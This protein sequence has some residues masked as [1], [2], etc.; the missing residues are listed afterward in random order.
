MAGSKNGIKMICENRK[1]RHEYQFLEL[2]EA[3][4]S[5]QGTE[6]KSLRLGR[7]NLQDA[8]A[9]VENGEMLL[10]NM[11]I[12]PYEMGNRF[13][14]QPKRTRR[15]LLHKSEIRHIYAKVREKGLTVI[16]VKAYF[17]GSRVKVELA[18]AQGKK[19]YDKRQDMIAKDA[20]RDME[21]AIKER[22]RS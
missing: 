13:N 12:S 21:R 15:L 1:A 16:P 14:H 2:F 3:G 17:S 22:N 20:K 6:V 10:Y 5:L 7:A 19:L 9:K 4:I 8:F 18:L 11:H